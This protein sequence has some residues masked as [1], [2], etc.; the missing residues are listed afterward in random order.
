MNEP[1]SADVSLRP[2]APGPLAVPDSP[3]PVEALLMA[4][5]EKGA[6][7]DTLERLLNL[8]ERVK[9]E[10][11]RSAYVEALSAFQA[12]CPVIPKTK[13]VSSG[14]Y[15]YKYAPLEVIVA[16]V[17]PLLRVHGLS[18]RFD[19][20]FEESPPAQV[21]TCTVQHLEGHSETSSFRTPVD[22]GARMN[23]M[24]KSASAQ[25]YAKRYAFCNALGILTGDEDNDG[26]SAGGAGGRVATSPQAARR[27]PDTSRQPVARSVSQGTSPAP[28]AGRNVIR[29]QRPSQE[30]QGSDGPAPQ[31]RSPVAETPAASESDAEAR[32]AELRKHLIEGQMALLRTMSK[33]TDFEPSD[34]WDR[35][36]EVV[37][38][39]CQMGFSRPL[40]EL[41]RVD[42]ER[43]KARMDVTVRE[44]TGEVA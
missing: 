5:V 41:S 23:D 20:A 24:Q 38:Q 1:T 8:S 37:N 22:A 17:Q 31:P 29:I 35:A 27:E 43:A 2:D 40:H 32:K 10:R 28:P 6:S 15:N 3:L 42:L 13:Q 30:S 16:A 4:A 18:Y 21:V 33:Y 34:L 11:A 36:T 39:W 44:R 19:T 25:T 12:D 26:Q 9:A 7:V 14:S